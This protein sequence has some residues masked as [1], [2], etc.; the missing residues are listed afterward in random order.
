MKSTFINFNQIHK[1]SSFIIN[2]I[3]LDTRICEQSGYLYNMLRN[4]IKLNERSQ[5][6]K[7]WFQA[8]FSPFLNLKLDNL[9][10]KHMIM[11][12]VPLMHEQ[13]DFQ[14]LI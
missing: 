3:N 5:S 8:P 7:V 13:V 9:S 14:Y 12:H 10:T 6:H 2:Q 4:I 11:I 1:Q